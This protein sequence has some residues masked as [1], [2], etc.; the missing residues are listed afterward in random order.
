MKKSIIASTLIL[1]TTF[2]F[3]FDLGSIAKSVVDNVTKEQT[4]T[5]KAPLAPVAT[6]ANT[7]SN[8]S[9]STVSSGLKEALKTGVNFAVTQLGANNGYLNNSAVKIP[10]PD[11]LAKAETLLRSAGGDKMADDL[12][13]SMNNAASK[14]APKT[15]EIFMNAIDKMSL[16]D[17]QSILAGGNEAATNYFKANTTESL[18]KLIAPIVQ[19]SMKE[20][21]VASYYD[22]I[23]NVYK[24]S[25]KGL[26]DNSGVMGMA[27]NFGVDSY[28][29]TSSDESLDSY[30]TTKAIDGLFTMIGQKEAAIRSNPVEQTT[31]I[32]KQVFGN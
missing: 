6:T 18:K 16:T 17:A 24:S 30:I 23:N 25:A 28:I 5:Q 7:N 8:I 32:L 12:I 31:S 22:T 10:L 14:A 21:N 13:N 3:A 27:K 4:T 26:V 1:T 20:N 11:N 2:T 9:D 15:A 19:E 29:P